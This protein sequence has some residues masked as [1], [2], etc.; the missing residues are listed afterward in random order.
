MS[1]SPS[2]SRWLDC[3]RAERSRIHGRKRESGEE[4]DQAAIVFGD[5]GGQVVI[6]DFARDAAQSGERMNMTAGESFEALAMGELEIQHAAVRIDQGESVE[7][8]H[9]A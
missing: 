9:V 8:A 3:R 7:L 2:P 1:S 6:G 5:R 4:A